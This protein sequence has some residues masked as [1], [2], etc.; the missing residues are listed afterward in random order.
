M[1]KSKK[2]IWTGMEISLRYCIARASDT[3][4]EK[5]KYTYREYTCICRDYYY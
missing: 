5:N 4:K 1:R 2:Y 3:Y